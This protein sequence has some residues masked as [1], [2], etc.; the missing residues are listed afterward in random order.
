MYDFFS[1]CWIW[2]GWKKKK[3]KRNLFPAI[4]LHDE[5][6]IILYLM[7]LFLFPMTI[8]QIH[9]CSQI[10]IMSADWRR[11]FVR[12]LWSMYIFHRALFHC[13]KKNKHS[14]RT[15]IFFSK[16]A[17]MFSNL[18]SNIILK[19][20]SNKC[21]HNI[22]ICWLNSNVSALFKSKQILP[23]CVCQTPKPKSSCKRTPEPISKQQ[24]WPSPLS[25]LYSRSMH[26]PYLEA[27]FS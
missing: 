14:L 13:K 3:K 15:L 18:I 26:T 10:V 19:C 20:F 22:Y 11:I 21:I 16:Y 27:I 1:N 25:K 5:M 12:K 6:V 24:F 4:N 8:Y 17:D 2:Y 23:K 7:I 9:W